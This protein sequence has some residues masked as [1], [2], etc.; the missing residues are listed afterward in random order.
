M[1]VPASPRE[2]RLIAANAKVGHSLPRDAAALAD[3]SDEKTE[4]PTLNKLRDA[5]KE[6]QASRSSDLTDA[7]SMSAVIL[8]LSAGASRFGDAMREGVLIATGFVN[9]DHSLHQP[10]DAAIQ[11]RRP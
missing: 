5:R 11:D 1:R 8:L 7:I 4:E 2:R 9:G 10:A 6:G 3:M